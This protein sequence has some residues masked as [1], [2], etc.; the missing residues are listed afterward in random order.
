MSP[1]LQENDRP[2]GQL[3]VDL[4]DVEGS[5]LDGDADPVKRH[6]FV[7]GVDV[8]QPRLGGIVVWNTNQLALM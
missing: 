6:R 8:V 5:I 7:S 4:D 1:A 3:V 2:V